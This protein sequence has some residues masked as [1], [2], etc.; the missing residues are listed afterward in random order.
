MP[1][2]AKKKKALN[3]HTVWRAEPDDAIRLAALRWFAL[4]IE[5]LS[6]EIYASD[7]SRY[8]ALEK[9]FR[10]TL[11]RLAGTKKDLTPKTDEE[12][13]CPEGFILCK[14]GLCAPMCDGIS[15]DT[16]YD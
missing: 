15:G 13:Q 4:Q 2:K 8:F 16:S 10:G 9:L 5:R 6:I 1:K 11:S 12:T 3:L 14:D 7:K